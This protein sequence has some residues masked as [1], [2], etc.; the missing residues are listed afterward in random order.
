MWNN[1]SFGRNYEIHSGHLFDPEG[2]HLISFDKFKR[3]ILN[4]NILFSLFFCT[5]HLEEP[6]DLKNIRLLDLNFDF[7]AWEDLLNNGWIQVKTIFYKS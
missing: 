4:H 5:N 7:E 6:S 2:N 1:F 3:V